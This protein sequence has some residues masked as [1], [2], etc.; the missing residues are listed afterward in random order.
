MMADLA[1]IAKGALSEL[2]AAV[3]L[4]IDIEDDDVEPGLSVVFTTTLWWFQYAPPGCTEALDADDRDLLDYVRG[5]GGNDSAEDR[6]LA[7]WEAG[8]LQYDLPACLW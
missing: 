8:G 3:A 4:G 2:A 7:L 5:V 6:C 1:E